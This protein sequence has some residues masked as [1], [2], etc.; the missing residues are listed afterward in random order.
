MI[1]S[2]HWLNYLLGGIVVLTL[3]LAFWW[4]TKKRGSR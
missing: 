1:P 4:I 3:C 2:E